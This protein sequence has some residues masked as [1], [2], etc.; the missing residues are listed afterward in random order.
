MPVVSTRELPAAAR[1]KAAVNGITLGTWV[2]KA[3]KTWKAK[4]QARIDA[5]QVGASGP[6]AV[7]QLASAGGAS[8]S[9]LTTTSKAAVGISPTP[10]V[11]FVPVA[12][13]PDGG[14]F[15]PL[16]SQESLIVPKPALQPFHYQGDIEG[17]K[18]ILLAKMNILLIFLP[19]TFWMQY[20]EYPDGQKFMASFFAMVPLAQILGDAT[21]ELAM[22]LNSDV[23]GGLLNATFG[24]A[25]EMILTVQTLRAGLIQ[26]VKDTLLGSVLS[27]LLLVLGM[28]FFFGGLGFYKQTFSREG[29]MVNVTMLLLASMSLALP[30]VFGAQLQMESFEQQLAVSRG[31]SVIVAITYVAYLIFQLFTH[32]DLFTEE[33]GDGDGEEEANLSAKAAL[34]LLAGATVLVAAASEVLVDPIDG[35]VSQYHIPPAFLGTIL[36]PIVGNACE[37][38]SAIRM[39]I[40]DR[41]SISI[42]IAVGSSTQISLFVVP[43]AVIL[44]WVLDQPMDLNFRPLNTV[45]MIL[46][47]LITWSIVAD[48]TS[49]WLVGFMLMVAY[50]IVCVLYWFIPSNL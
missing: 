6:T 30:T 34:G 50:L 15:S 27:N 28:S 35:V 25:V 40:Q 26:V 19:I 37:H 7:R 17:L 18:S 47:V 45:I 49:N 24:N 14:R 9:P 23:I 20:K 4:A 16:P 5:S 36:L 46:S 3:A 43:F 29:A 21:E 41:M 1:H 2:F 44:G 38:A 31:I 39:A 13:G 8:Q 48:G 22:V 12:V 32:P 11:P 33:E 10:S 42:G